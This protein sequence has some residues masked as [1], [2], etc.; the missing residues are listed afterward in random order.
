MIVVKG[1]RRFI[2]TGL[3]LAI[4][5]VGCYKLIRDEGLK[6]DTD[7]VVIGNSQIDTN[8][9][10][11]VVSEDSISTTPSDT[12]FDVFTIPNGLSYNLLT[13]QRWR[14]I[15]M[16]LSDYGFSG[17]NNPYGLPKL[18]QMQNPLE[19]LLCRR[20]DYSPLPRIGQDN[21]LR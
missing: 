2:L 5:N 4:A 14:T 17:L 20:V 9:L 6:V 21:F 19:D 18:P 16:E 11:D 8:K 1:V 3:I 7:P 15:E 13:T 12:T 10:S